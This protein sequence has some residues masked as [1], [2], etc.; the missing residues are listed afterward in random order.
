MKEINIVTLLRNF[1]LKKLASNQISAE[2]FLVLPI[3]WLGTYY[4]PLYS[5]IN[6]VFAEVT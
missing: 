2:D 4:Q 1:G 3:F 5:F 6:L